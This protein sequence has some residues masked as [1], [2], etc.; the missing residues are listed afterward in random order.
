MA[1]LGKNS[2]CLAAFCTLVALT[3]SSC[4]R[5]GINTII[6]DNGGKKNIPSDAQATPNPSI[7]NQ[8]TNIPNFQHQGGEESGYYI[9]RLDMTGIQNPKTYE[10]IRLVGTGGENG[11]KQNV[12]LSVDGDPKGISVHNTIDDY[13]E[14]PEVKNDVIFLIDN[15]GSMSDEA[16]AIA[17]DIVAWSQKLNSDRS[18]Q[19]GAVG[20]D[21]SIRGGIDLTGFQQLSDWLNRSTGVNRTIGFAGS[22]A[23]TLS[24]RASNYNVSTT[25]MESGVAALRFADENYT[26]RYGANRI[27]IN[28]TD[29]SNYTGGYSKYSVSYLNSSSWDASKGTVHTVFSDS[30]SSVSVSTNYEYPWLM[31]QYT[32]G[33]VL[34]TNSSFT[35]VTL[36]DLP[37]TSAIQN[38]YIIR[39][40]ISSAL[41]D[42]ASHKVRITVNTEDNAVCA[43]KTFSVVFGNK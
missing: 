27:Y 32:G 28:F 39:F 9:V 40:I 26:F 29:E 15:S 6:L 14:L 7:D 24:S 2:R 35:G 30:K 25:Q 43:D 10:W 20:Y 17:R 8:T 3:L 38:S 16:N 18:V 41:L 37:I 11:M 33:T 13:T 1:T 21:G 36:D 4:L 5:D 22:N 19:F 42:G 23:T 31:S 12:W 34:Y